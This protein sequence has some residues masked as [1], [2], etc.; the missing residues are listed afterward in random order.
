MPGFTE[1]EGWAMS[2]AFSPDGRFAL[3][4][5]KLPS[6]LRIWDME[7]GQVRTLDT[8]VPGEEGCMPEQFRGAVGEAQVLADGRLLTFGDQGTR[9]WDLE[10]G[11]NRRIQSCLEGQDRHLVLD[12]ARR[13]ALVVSFDNSTHTSTFGS[14]DVE[15]GSFQEIRSHGSNVFS[16]AFDPT[17]TVIVTG[18]YDGVV[19]VGPLAGGEPHLLYGHTFEVSSI[20]VSPDGKWIASGSQDGTIRLWPMPEGKPFQTLPYEELL[21]RLRGL[22]NL[23]VVPEENSDSGYRVEIGRFPGWKRLP[24]W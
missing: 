8:R 19:R 16:I 6:L 4:V 13:R 15:T 10:R 7:S 1:G 9:I 14:L 2:P 24:E 23:R 17:G 20:A 5:G 11:T 3:A 21:E 22:T 18:S 12:R